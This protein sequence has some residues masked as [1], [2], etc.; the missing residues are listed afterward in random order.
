MYMKH[1]K[2]SK[3]EIDIIN[4][5]NNGELQN[6]EEMNFYFHYLKIFKD[7]YL[8]F[9]YRKH[10]DKN[11]FWEYLGGVCLTSLPAGCIGIICLFAG[12]LPLA[13]LFFSLVA[14]GVI[15][16]DILNSFRAKKEYKCELQELASLIE[17]ENIRIRNDKELEEQKRKRIEE[18]NNKK[19]LFILN[20]KKDIESI[21]TSKYEGYEKDILALKTLG[22]KYLS[23]KKLDK[24]TSTSE[25]LTMYPQFNQI[26]LAIENVINQNVNF[27]EK[28]DLDI[29]ELENA[30]KEFSTDSTHLM[31]SEELFQYIPRN[32]PNL[33][34]TS[35]P[36]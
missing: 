13:F 18:E 15:V 10:R 35:S 9:L 21:L 31:S 14:A 16:P 32:N 27:K 12:N 17:K 22:Y 23:L 33:K 36:N 5:G 1:S 4:R 7:E 6:L 24:T 26:L 29:Q 11:F 30:L 25:I 2:F 20:I 34:L 8:K 3:E 28:Q 19:D